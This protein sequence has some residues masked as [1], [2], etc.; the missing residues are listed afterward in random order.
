MCDAHVGGLH[1]AVHQA[2]G[3]E[4]TQ[5]LGELTQRIA[6]TAFVDTG[7]RGRGSAHEGYRRGQGD[8][9]IAGGAGGW[10]QLV[11]RVRL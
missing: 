8:G 4:G 1:V 10:R 6:K 9:V 5:R 7:L 3:V 2:D 11:Q